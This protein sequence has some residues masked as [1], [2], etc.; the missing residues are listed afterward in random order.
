MDGVTTYSKSYIEMGSPMKE[1][2]I[3]PHSG[4][5]WLH[6]NRTFNSRTCYND[7]YIPQTTEHIVPI[8]PCGNIGLSDKKMASDTTNKVNNI[9]LQKK[10]CKKN[11]F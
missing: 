5:D 10:K 8:I 4:A 7:A 3:L 2:P 11:Y 6:G 9:F 1:K